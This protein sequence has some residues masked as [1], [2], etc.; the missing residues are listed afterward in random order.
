MADALLD[1]AAMLDEYFS[2]TLDMETRVLRTLPILLTGYTPDMHK[3]PS[4]MLRLLTDVSYDEEKACLDGVLRELAMFY[5][6]SSPEHAKAR[7]Q[8]SSPKSDA[9]QEFERVVAHIVFP[10]MKRFYLPSRDMQEY[11][12][13]LANLPDLYRVFERC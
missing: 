6:V 4:L 7:E 1:H 11:V 8:Q 2:I 10:A 3:L 12:K 9:V 5:R 13:A